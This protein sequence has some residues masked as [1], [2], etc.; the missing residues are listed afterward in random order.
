MNG[1]RAILLLLAVGL[2]LAAWMVISMR[3]V[4]KMMGPDAP[5]EQ[6]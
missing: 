5:V 1:R 3:G 4:P 6:R 2:V